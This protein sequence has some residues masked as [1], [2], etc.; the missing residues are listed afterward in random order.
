MNTKQVSTII[1]L[2]GAMIF[3]TGIATYSQRAAVI[4][5]GVI[6]TLFGIALERDSAQ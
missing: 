4:C 6:L 1:Q 2:L 3:V 5:G